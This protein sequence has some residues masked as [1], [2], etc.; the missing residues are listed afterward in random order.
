MALPGELGAAIGCLTAL[1][2]PARRAARDTLA[3]GLALYPAVGLGIGA[4][5]A[6]VAALVGRV[7]PAAAGVVGVLVVAAIEGG[8]PIGGLGSAAE[9]LL[10]PGAPPAVLAR[11]RR[12]PGPLG[13]AVALAAL[14]TRA[15][16]AALLPAPA[17]TTALLV[18]PMLGAWSVVV[19]CYGGSP[20]HA[21][22]IA[23]A[24]VG[25]SRFREFAWASVVALGVTLAVAEPIGLVVVVVASLVTVGVRVLAHRR[26]G[27][28]D[29]RLLG[30]SRELV[31][32]AVL[33]VL[34]GLAALP[35]AS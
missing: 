11:L 35:P 17:R 6:G 16:A 19:Q 4:L 29:G 23:A 32:T 27:G 25:R 20:V 3:A 9:A 34:G 8:R 15:A 26:V 5:G 22:G 1:T 30:A 33:A 7:S 14:G 24:L 12:A 10:R 28:L 2:R 13:I 31:E 21:R 18:A